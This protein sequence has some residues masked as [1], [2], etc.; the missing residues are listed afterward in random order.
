[1]TEAIQTIENIV[2]VHDGKAVTDSLKVAAVFGKQHKHVLE[3]IRNLQIPDE[4]RLPN[5]RPTVITRPNP[6]GGKDIASNAYTM[7]RDGF[8]ILAMGFTS[9]KAMQFKWAYIQAFNRMEARLNGT[10]KPEDILKDTLDT[11]GA[12]WILDRIQRC[13][14]Y[15]SFYAPKHKLGERNAKGHEHSTIRRASNPVK[16]GRIPS[17][18][19]RAIITQPHLFGYSLLIKMNRQ[20]EK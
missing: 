17:G 11:F 5:F 10:M 9:K 1:M 19:E 4:D 14:I 18:R 6:S 13:E 3:A 2:S 12:D 16:G 20:I 7:T 8:T 15:D